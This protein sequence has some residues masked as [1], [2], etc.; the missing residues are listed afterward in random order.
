MAKKV[1]F[2]NYLKAQV[3]VMRSF[4]NT[5]TFCP[6]VYNGFFTTNE[7]DTSKMTIK[8]QWGF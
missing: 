4:V 7:I 8:E 2:D 5:N 6:F 1:N 3:D